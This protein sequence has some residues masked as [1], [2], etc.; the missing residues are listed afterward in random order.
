ME[1][2]AAELG[3]AFAGGQGGRPVAA[4]QLL[5]DLFPRQAPSYLAS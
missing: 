3:S 5:V 1:R 2:R 4:D